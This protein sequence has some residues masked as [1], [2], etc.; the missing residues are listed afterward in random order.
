M[1]WSRARH[2][3]SGF[4]R[5]TADRFMGAL[6]VAGEKDCPGE[7]DPRGCGCLQ[8]ISTGSSSTTSGSGCNTVE[9]RF[10]GD[11][12][13]KLGKDCEGIDGA[14]Y[15]SA[16]IPLQH[17]QMLTL[18]DSDASEKVLRFRLCCTGEGSGRAM[19]APTSL[20]SSQTTGRWA[21]LC[22]MVSGPQTI[23]VSA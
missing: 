4:V 9:F 19:S 22:R 20:G 12:R 7:A 14:S 23:N 2:R 8:G 16:I 1:P 11:D 21:R 5:T 18:S 6:C 10:C 15:H 13:T 17:D 3:S